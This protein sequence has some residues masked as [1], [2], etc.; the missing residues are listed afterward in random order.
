MITFPTIK[1]DRCSGCGLCITVCPDRTLTLVDGIA[2]ASGDKC[3]ACGHCQAVCP[4]QAIEIS[5]VYAD[6]GF[7]HIEEKKGWLAPGAMAAADLVQLLRSRRSVRSYHEKPVPLAYLEDLVKIGTTA[8]SGTNS[9]AWTFTI[10]KNRGEVELLGGLTA[11]FFHRLNKKAASPLWR[12]AARI[13]AGDSLGRYYRRHYQTVREGLVDWDERGEDHLFHGAPAAI[14]VGGRQ[15]ASC[16]AED[17]LLA[18]GNMLLGAHALG[19]STCLIGFVVE[20][21]RHDHAIGASL[22]I[23]RDEEIYA[24]IAVG[25]GREIYQ[26]PAPRKR[27]EIRWLNSAPRN[28]GG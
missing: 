1:L 13:F 19:L 18:S 14:L 17:A 5:E 2:R 8:P 12:L 20:A 22:G 15:E 21:M 27:V 24:V 16:P 6:L 10:L 23:A 26:R 25:Y 4:V 9:Q 11:A 3:M 7:K 28:P